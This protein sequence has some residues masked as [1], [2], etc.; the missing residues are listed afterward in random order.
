MEQFTLP[1]FGLIDLDNIEEYYD[2]EVE[3]K[4]AEVSLDINF[5]ESTLE[6]HIAMR[7]KYI[8]E[9]IEVYDIKNRVYIDA[10]YAK[11]N[12]SLVSDFVNYHLEEIGDEIGEDINIDL[13]ASD[14]DEQFIKKLKLIRLGLYPDSK[15]ENGGFAVF[16]YSIDPEVTDQL[17]VVNVDAEGNLQHISWES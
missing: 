4:D 6:Q 17:L 12:N 13:E 2:A 7:I 1:H 5:E 14:R 11:E 15:S 3:Y 8:L 16:D 10:N 9:N